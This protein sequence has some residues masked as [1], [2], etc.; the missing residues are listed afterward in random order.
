[1][2]NGTEVN[3]DKTGTRLILRP[4]IIDCAEGMP[5]EHECDL[6]RS[7]TYYLECVVILGIFGKTGLNLSLTGNTD[8][9]LDQS[10]DSFKSCMVHL[11]DQFGA[12]NTLDIQVKKRGYAP[13]G[14]GVVKVTQQYVKQL[15]SISIIDEGKVKRIRGLVTSAKVSPQLTTRVVDKLREVF[16]DY[17]PDVWIHTD[18]YKKG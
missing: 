16:N 18:H 9:D 12:P 6:S 2:T 7:I 4:G 14:G 8:D 3:I 15:D 5:I 17:I 13:K 1:M 10:I 11:L